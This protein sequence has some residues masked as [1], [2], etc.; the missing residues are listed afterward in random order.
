ML[1]KWILGGGGVAVVIAAGWGVYSYFDKEVTKM[2]V[3]LLWHRT[4][5]GAPRGQCS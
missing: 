2:E 5:T 4:S 3:T 1:P